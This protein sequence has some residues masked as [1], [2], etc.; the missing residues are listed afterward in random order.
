MIVQIHSLST[1]LV[2]S[3]YFT[4]KDDWIDS[5]SIGDILLLIKSRSSSFSGVPRYTA[6]HNKFG[7]VNM[8]ISNKTFDVLT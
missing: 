7:L 1:L 6:L 5:I 4:E 3:C 2:Q 8:Y